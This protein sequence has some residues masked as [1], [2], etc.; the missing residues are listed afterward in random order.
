MQ[1]NN[2]IKQSLVYE[3]TRQN[4]SLL[5]ELKEAHKTIAKLN[6]DRCVMKDCQLDIVVQLEKANEKIHQ[7][8]VKQ[9]QSNPKI[10]ELNRLLI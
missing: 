5:M 10:V 1:E 2:L 3:L 9:E 7:L 4:H 6:F 8:T